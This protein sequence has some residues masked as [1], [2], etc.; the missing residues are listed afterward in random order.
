[1]LLSSMYYFSLP[2]PPLSISLLAVI[3][4]FFVWVFP[5]FHMMERSGWT[6]SLNSSF[7]VFISFQYVLCHLHLEQIA[8]TKR[9]FVHPSFAF[10]LYHSL[11]GLLPCSLLTPGD[12]FWPPHVSLSLLQLLSIY[13]SFTR[14]SNRLSFGH[15]PDLDAMLNGQLL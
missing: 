2:L 8:C 5:P 13:G 11:F 9:L 4:M 14:C 12:I 15:L 6:L 10:F 3:N 1:M 7:L